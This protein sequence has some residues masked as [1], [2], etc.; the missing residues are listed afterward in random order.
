MPRITLY[1][2]TAHDFD[3]FDDRF[4]MR[5]SEPNAGLGI[6]LTQSPALAAE[7]A[8]KSKRDMHAT[9][10]RVLVVEADVERAALVT[11]R[12]CFIGRSEEG[13]FAFDLDFMTTRE[14]FVG[15]RLRLEAEGYHAIALDCAGDDLSECWA[16]FD[17]KRLRVIGEMSV[18][19]AYEADSSEVDGVEFEPVRMFA[20]VLEHFGL[21]ASP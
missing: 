19:E 1:H 18:D 15:E 9:R 16:V 8:E 4:A 2:G 17:P 6:H 11:S 20:D 13:E 7:Y 14:E 12:E 10:P 5:G 3:A 21:D